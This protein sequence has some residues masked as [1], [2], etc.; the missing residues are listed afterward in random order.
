MQLQ[1]SSNSVIIFIL[2]LEVLSELENVF[3]CTYLTMFRCLFLVLVLSVQSCTFRDQNCSYTEDKRTYE[4]TQETISLDSIELNLK[5]EG[6]DQDNLHFCAYNTTSDTITISPVYCISNQS[7]PW[8]S[9]V[10]GRID[11]F[12]KIIPPNKELSFMINLGLDSIE[13]RKECTY[14]ITIKGKSKAKELLLYK[15]LKLGNRYKLNGETIL[16]PDTIIFPI[17]YIDNETK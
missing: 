16:E 5:P 6:K 1:L 3:Y 13:Y 9:M 2:V 7:A 17:S 14:N 10:I 11:A 8:V 4:P 12:H 15:S